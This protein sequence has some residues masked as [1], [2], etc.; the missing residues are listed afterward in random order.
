MAET[1]ADVVVGL[2]WLAVG[3]SLLGWRVRPG[4][5][6]LMAA[7][8]A[9]WL[10][11]SAFDRLA[12]LHRGPLVHVLLAYPDGALAGLAA[13]A[14]VGGGYLEGVVPP[15]GRLPVATGLLVVGVLGV[16]VRRWLRGTGVVRR[17][18]AA[19]VIA[20]ALIGAVLATGAA[21]RPAGD[22]LA[23][24]YDIVL[25]GVALMLLADLR[26]A[27]WGREAVTGLV[28]ELGAGAGDT[29]TRR[30]ARAVGD[31]SLRAVFA[32]ADGVTFVDEAGQAVELADG[33]P[34]RAVTRFAEGGRAVAAVVHDP[35]AL[36]DPE[37]VA[38][39]GAALR[40]A[41]ANVRLQDDVRRRVADVEASRRRLLQASDEQRR[42]IVSELEAGVIPHLDRAVAALAPVGA[43]DLERRLSAAGDQLRTLAFGLRPP[44]LVQL[45]LS[46]ALRALVADVP[47]EVSL[48]AP[49]GRFD[50]E[51]EAT[52]WFVCSE[53]L[54][55]ALKHAR[56]TCM[57][58]RVGTG[59]DRL[60]VEVADDGVG[61]A[62][63]GRGSGLRRLAARVEA[64][65]GVLAVHDRTGGGTRLVAELPGGTGG[66]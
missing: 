19:P 13:R 25:I 36:R 16:A 6:A 27:A 39:A 31:P 61:G 32:L 63:P 22:W 38:G 50:R 5:G 52:A 28:I 66:E 20:A 35:S 58:I 7:T 57:E 55:N 30:L 1:A 62:D 48:V 51:L 2:V 33:G 42:W 21:G 29:V 23:L 60:T 14:T 12:L 24:G 8:G 11:G 37:L 15:V 65:G 53:A 40:I 59:E 43:V 4:T 41:V 34:D 47:L 3:G 49:R 10:A 9:A 64:V 44:A 56:A 45:G 46:G 26:W 54:A 17:S 18:R